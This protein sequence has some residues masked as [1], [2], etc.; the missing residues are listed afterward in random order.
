[1]S[2]VGVSD[3]LSKEE[4]LAIVADL[5]AQLERAAQPAPALTEC[6]RPKVDRM[7]SEVIHSNPYRCAA[8][9]LAARRR[10]CAAMTAVAASWP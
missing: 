7:S 6:G 10:V 4:L 8:V 9:Q 5:R 3:A 1:M 2:E